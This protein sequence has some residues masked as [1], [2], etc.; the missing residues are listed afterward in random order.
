MMV[1]PV[2]PRRPCAQPTAPARA[3]ASCLVASSGR[4]LPILGSRS[5]NLP[6]AASVCSFNAASTHCGCTAWRSAADPIR[7]PGR[8]G[9]FQA[10]FGCSH[11]QWLRTLCEPVGGYPHGRSGSRAVCVLRS[12]KMLSAVAED[13]KACLRQTQC[14]ARPTSRRAPRQRRPGPR[15]ARRGPPRRM[16]SRRP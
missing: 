7:V 12:V 10:A 3:K 13:A 1:W 16:R 14:C 5:S 6:V 8:L 11:C 15:S 2:V 4:V 9:T